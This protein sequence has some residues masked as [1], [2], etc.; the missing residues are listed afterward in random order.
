MAPPSYEQALSPDGSG[1]PAIC[2]NR[3]A[4]PCE[5]VPRRTGVS[6]DNPFVFEDPQAGAKLLI[7]NGASTVS[8]GNRG[9]QNLAPGPGKATRT[10]YTSERS[11]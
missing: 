6:E 3:L 1:G 2:M 11:D 9:A 5:R 8:G 10:V 7:Q 4:H